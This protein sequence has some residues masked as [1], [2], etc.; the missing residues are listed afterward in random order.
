M[1]HNPD[2]S[3]PLDCTITINHVGQPKEK[4]GYKVIICPDARQIPAL[5]GQPA[6]FTS[7]LRADAPAF[8]PASAQP[9]STVNTATEPSGADDDNEE[10]A[11]VDVVVAGQDEAEIPKEE[12]PEPEE[13]IVRP[14]T[15]EE[16]AAAVR[17]QRIYRESRRRRQPSSN[18]RVAACREFFMQAQAEA[19]SIQW[20]SKRYRLLFLG[21]VPHAMVCLDSFLGWAKEQKQKNKNRFKKGGHE[22][23]ETNG[24]ALTGI[25]QLLKSVRE[26]KEHLEPKSKLH[27]NRDIVQL[28]NDVRALQDLFIRL[29]ASHSGALS[30]VD[31][32]LA[33][34]VQSVIVGPVKAAVEA[35]P[36]LNTDDLD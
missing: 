8:V 28:K 18:A 35:K 2:S 29:R 24:K 13:A 17:I 21:A 22:D 9:S 3:S 6:P 30:E 16:I 33:V 27:K 5:L 11:V 36:S 14:P 4:P 25:V 34:V 12:E 19:S 10:E 32:D 31:E 1:I 23:I 26:L 20:K 15:E 7:K